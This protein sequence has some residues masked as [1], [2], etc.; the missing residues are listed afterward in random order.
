MQTI[1]RKII[2]FYALP[3]RIDLYKDFDTDLIKQTRIICCHCIRKNFTEYCSVHLLIP[4]R[5]PE[6]LLDIMNEDEVPPYAILSGPYAGLC[7][8]EIDFNST[9]Y[10]NLQAKIIRI[11]E[12]IET[13]EDVKKYT[14]ETPG[15][16]ILTQAAISPFHTNRTNKYIRMGQKELRKLITNES[17]LLMDDPDIKEALEALNINW[18]AAEQFIHDKYSN[19]ANLSNHIKNLDMD[20]SSVIDKI[21]QERILENEDI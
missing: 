18:I 1:I 13:W 14:Y 10:L 5:I 21:K 2:P 12:E 16:R 17:S 15:L 3:N 9:D 7:C 20:A 11:P 4:A 19:T 8:F 6:I